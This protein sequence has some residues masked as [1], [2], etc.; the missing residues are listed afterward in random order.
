M[1]D[2]I[3]TERLRIRPFRPDDWQAVLASSSDEATTHYLNEPAMTEERAQAWTA[4]QAGAEA[5][6]VAL[7][8]KPDDSPI[9]HLVFHLWLFRRVRMRSGGSFVPI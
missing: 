7:V 3:E 1:I 9:G 4:E 8:V 2:Q 5:R 6:A